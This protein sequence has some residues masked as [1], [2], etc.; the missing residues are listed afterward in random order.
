MGRRYRWFMHSLKR[1]IML[2]LLVWGAFY[3]KNLFWVSYDAAIQ[4]RAESE[5]MPQIQQVDAASVEAFL[6][7]GN[8]HTL[9]VIYSSDSALSRWYFG[10][11]NAIA[12]RY[13]PAG[14]RPLFISVDAD[15]VP[16]SHFLASRDK[17]AFTPLYMQPVE[18]AKMR[19]VIGRVGGD[20]NSGTLPYMGV[21]G[22]SG[23]VTNF[24]PAIVRTGKIEQVLDQNLKGG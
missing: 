5:I 11:L 6:K 12:E 22:S 14:V 18:A 9:V 4:S 24:S 2:G 7:Q 13:A 15:P 21:I 10:D 20:F 3:V 19:S 8:V 17:L 16:L 1:F 23:Y